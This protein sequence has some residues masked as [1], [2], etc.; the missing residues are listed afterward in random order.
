[1][2]ISKVL[3]IGLLMFIVSG[4]YCSQSFQN[5]IP[6]HTHV[7]RKLMA[8]YKTGTGVKGTHVWGLWDVG[9]SRQYSTCGTGPW[10][11]KYRDT[12]DAGI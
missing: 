1:M 5:I 12:G 4:L 10:D 3:I 8:V 11:V 7:Y 2:S 9:T 6:Y